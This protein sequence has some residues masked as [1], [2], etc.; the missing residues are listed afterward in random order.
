MEV[1]IS[2]LPEH[3]EGLVSKENL[4]PVLGLVKIVIK[5]LN[6][7]GQTLF[8]EFW[9]LVTAATR[10]GVTDSP[11]LGNGI[12]VDIIEFCL[13]AFARIQEL[14][15]LLIFVTSYEQLG[16]IEAD[17]PQYLY[18]VR[19]HSAVIH[20]LGELDVAEVA[21]TLLESSFTGDAPILFGCGAES[22]VI[23]TM[24]SWVTILVVRD[25]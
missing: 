9:L 8:A 19:Q 23:D 13:C 25:L 17:R 5:V 6:L 24:E 11:F 20:S 18:Q 16:A 10:L 3:L 1:F 2:D 4:L 7:D 22:R 21:W 12:L 14:V 15:V